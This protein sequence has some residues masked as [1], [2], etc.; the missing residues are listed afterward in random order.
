VDKER[1]RGECKLAKKRVDEGKIEGVVERIYGPE[2][3]SEEEDTICSWGLRLGISNSQRW[4]SGTQ[5]SFG[6]SAR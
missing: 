5:I 4:A 6:R 1:E 2:E 3:E